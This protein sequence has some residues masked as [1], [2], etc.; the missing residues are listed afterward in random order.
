MGMAVTIQEHF[1]RV[2]D[3]GGESDATLGTE[4][5]NWT[6]DT[7]T[8][9]RVRFCITETGGGTESQA[10]EL[11]FNL[12]GAG[13]VDVTGSSAIQYTSS[14]QSI[15]DG[16]AT[17]TDRV[18]GTGSYQQGEY[19]EDAL[20]EVIS[21]LSSEYTN[22]EFCLT[23]DSAQVNDAETFDLQVF[24]SVDTALD[25]YSVTP[26]ITVNKPV[27]RIPRHGFT[28]FQTPGVV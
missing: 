15:T 13:Y 26:T 20:T 11:R 22:L 8:I 10:Y 5:A 7:D 6:Q 23:I 16:D 9:F 28:N 4:D 14:T 21:G 18:S 2:F 3:D 12:E 17:V 24:F 25:S 19:S 1:N 27:T